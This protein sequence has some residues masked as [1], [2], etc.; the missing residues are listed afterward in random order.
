MT[1]PDAPKR[2][3]GTAGPPPGPEQGPDKGDGTDLV[4]VMDRAGPAEAPDSADPVA[5]TPDAPPP[6]T[7]SA[8]QP[9][10]T[11]EKNG[12]A[13]DAAGTGAAIAKSPPKN[14]PESKA[15]DAPDAPTSPD[16]PDNI[17]DEL[18]DPYELDELEEPDVA[19][20]DPDGDGE[21]DEAAADQKAARRDERAPR[22]FI[23][24]L[25]RRILTVNL[26][27]LVI[28]IFG[29]LYLGQY[30]DGLIETELEALTVQGQI[31]A[32]ALGEGAT[33]TDADGTQVLMPRVARPMLRR[34]V[35]PT[36]TRAQIFNLSGG[37][38]ADSRFIAGP[39]GVVQV[40]TLPPPQEESWHT[41]FV[42]D[43]FDVVGDAVGSNRRLPVFRD[44]PDASADDHA[45]VR[46]ALAGETVRAVMAD[47]AGA[48]VL[49][50][51]VPVERFKRV[52]AA[53]MLVASGAEI[54]TEVREVRL[55][56]LRIFGIALAVTVLMS[57]YLAG[58]I[59]RPV[60]RLAAAARQMRAGASQ[61]VAIPDFT[62]R[63]DEI[64]EL[65]GA[66]R[67]MTDALN[68]RI[69]AIESFAADVAHEIK[70]PLTSLRS[71]VETAA[72]VQNPEQ[73]RELMG[74]IQEDVQR[75]DRLITD[76]SDA[77]RLDAE[78]ARADT[79]EVDLGRLLGALVQVHE[80]TGA[81]GRAELKLEQKRGDKVTVNGIEGRLVQVFQNLI[82][83]AFSFSPPFTRITITVYRDGP[84]V[85]AMVDDEG[86]GIPDGSEESIFERFYSERPAGELFGRH[87]GLGLSI[88]RQ[89]V[90]A[91]GGAIRAENRLD[92]RGAVLGARFRVRLPSS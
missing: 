82:S 87:S 6:K 43:L 60:R 91:H 19:D 72:R 22:R 76:I 59:T 52:Q 86:P 36:R 90:E 35:E 69:Q 4:T 57:L 14:A 2:Q 67:E 65:S 25:T 56:I 81:K 21:E 11:S 9:G 48:M 66:L 79:E 7:K 84:M 17:P 71:A 41:G 5:K 29:L 51:A 53:L 24:P 15:P 62:S 3:A 16:G 54:G 63:G 12:V 26:I 89:I 30:E 18:D 49:I 55:Q 73:Q 50:A 20:D 85:E 70:N 37:M 64:G 80:S 74:I 42:L 23:S 77:S 27:A 92:D 10:T 83:N 75:L 32:G 68:D 88:S 1:R 40:E 78:L 61:E 33:G 38:M 13:A 28:P 39:G 31:F 58:A 34:L 47:S 45:L 44:P 8:I 46:Q